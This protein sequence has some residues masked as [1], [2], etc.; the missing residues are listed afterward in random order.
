MEE[1]FAGPKKSTVFAVPLVSQVSQDSIFS[2]SD[3]HATEIQAPAGSLGL[4]ASS[5]TVYLSC[6]KA[7]DGKFPSAA[8]WGVLRLFPRGRLYDLTLLHSRPFSLSGGLPQPRP[9]IRP[10]TTPG[11]LVRLLV[12]C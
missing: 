5:A 2:Q 11:V 10:S 12:L 8:G 6:R 9:E 7:S 4:F 3:G 1:A